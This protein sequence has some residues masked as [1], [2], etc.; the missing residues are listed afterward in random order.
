M[1]S[2]ERFNETKVPARKYFCSSTKD[3]KFG[4]NGKI[5]DE[6]ISVKDY[7]TCPKKFGISLA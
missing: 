3:E 7:L 2:F 6:H 4:D 1:D 5:S